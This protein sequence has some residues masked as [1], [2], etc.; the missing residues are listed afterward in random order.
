VTG[1]FAALEARARTTGAALCIGIDP[2]ADDAGAALAAARHLVAATAPVAAAFKPNAAFFEALGPEG[3]EVLIEVVAAIPEEIP[4]ILDAKRG[5]ISST[6]EAY[7]TAAFSVIGAGAITVS[8]YLGRDAIAPFLAHADRAVWVLCHTSNPSSAELQDAVLAGG[9]TLAE[10]V[11]RRAT[12]WAGPD[13][14]G[15]VVGANRPGALAAIRAVA[16]DHWILAPGVGAQ[17]G[18]I[19]DLADGLRSG[20]GGLLVPV[21]RSIAA[22]ADP[23]AAAVELRD[24][25]R[26]LRPRPTVPPS[27]STELFNSGCVRTGE[28]TLRS[29]AVSPIYLDL[30]RLMGSPAVLRRVA[31][32]VGALVAGLEHDHLG[33]VPYGAIPLATAVSLGTH[34]S[35]LWPRPH[36]KDHGTGARVEGTWSP[37]DRVVLVDDVA[38]S[39]ASGLEAAAGLREAGLVVEHLVVVVE[40]DPAARIALAAAGITLHAVTTLAGVVADLAA[41]GLIA[42]ALRDD[43]ER[44]LG[45]T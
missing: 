15:L 5:D 31:R 16:P 20:G 17:G 40:R 22:A 25:L 41:V 18:G 29:G 28:F 21:A 11:A 19:D 4:V 30:R 24:A 33:A 35:L 43:I 27:V 44:Y 13:R 6:A 39:G 14:L 10:E 2:R 23:G 32:R 38:T 1:F 37:G 34:T 3:I 8:P 7:A 36:A 45:R 9:E 42:G 26:T 12:G